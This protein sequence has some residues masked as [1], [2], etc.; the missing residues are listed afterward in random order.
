[1]PFG[2]SLVRN[3]LM[4]ATPGSNYETCTCRASGTRVDNADRGSRIH[5]RQKLRLDESALLVRA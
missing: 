5:D 1:M 2:S 4:L 3:D